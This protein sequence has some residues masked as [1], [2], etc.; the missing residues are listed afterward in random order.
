MAKKNEKEEAEHEFEKLHD[1]ISSLHLE[2]STLAK[3]SSNDALNKF[4]LKVVNDILTRSNGFLGEKYKPFKDFERFEDESIPT[5]SDV[6]MMLGQYL[7]CVEKLR[8]DQS[9]SAGSTTFGGFDG[10]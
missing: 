6:T 3:K 9:K 2:L 7:A 8:Y 5:N 4:K 1:Q 10:F